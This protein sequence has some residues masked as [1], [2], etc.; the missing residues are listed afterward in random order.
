MKTVNRLLLAAAGRVAGMLVVTCALA[1]AISDLH[2]AL[3]EAQAG[4]IDTISPTCASVGD[5][6][7][8]TGIGFGA[9]NVTIAV[10]GVPASIVTAN[11][12]SATFIVPAGAGLGSTTVSATNPG[13]QSG[14]IAFTVCDLLT[15]GAW[16]GEWEII[17]SYSNATNQRISEKDDITTFIRTG[18]RFGLSRVVQAGNCTGMVSDTHLEIHCSGNSS[19]GSCTTL[20]SDVQVSADRSDDSIAGSGTIGLTVTGSC[21]PFATGTRSVT[22]SGRRLSLNQDTFGPPTTL[23]KS[24]VPYGALMSS[25]Q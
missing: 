1:L 18:E 23:L 11:G 2:P 25:G 19:G 21:S 3:V 13:G 8:I 4:R 10:G 15:P 20:A 9:Q 7:T 5:Q 14:S 24:F 16:G 6:V 17:T 12:H 22:I